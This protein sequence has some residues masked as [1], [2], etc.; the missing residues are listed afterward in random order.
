MLTTIQ[1][2]L[3]Y[4]VMDLSDSCSTD[5]K[6]SM[7]DTT[8]ILSWTDAE[9][10]LAPTVAVKSDMLSI[11][12][13]SLTSAPDDLTISDDDTTSVATSVLEELRDAP[14]SESFQSCTSP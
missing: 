6:A 7:I 10:S 5:P 4:P 13:N 14:S 9:N 1:L 8:Q 3:V 12:S 2:H 11:L